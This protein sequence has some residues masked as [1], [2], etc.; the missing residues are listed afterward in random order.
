M[1]PGILPM[2]NYIKEVRIVVTLQTP[3]IGALIVRIGFWGIL[4]Y[5]YTKDHPPQKKNIY[6]YIYI[7]IGNY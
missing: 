3:N 6:T 1:I 2:H 4:Y 5:S 7:Y